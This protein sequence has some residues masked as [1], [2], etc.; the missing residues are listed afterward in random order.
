MNVQELFFERRLNLCRKLGLEGSS[1]ALITKPAHI[2]YF[3][4]LYIM[5]YERFIGLVLSLETWKGYL[6]IP[7]LEKGLPAPKDIE[8]IAYR[9][10]EDPFLKLLNIIKNTQVLWV[11]KNEISLLAFEK[12]MKLKYKLEDIFDLGNV[13]EE[14]KMIKDAVEIN[15]LGTAAHYADEIL[16]QVKKAIKVGAVEKQIKFE[17]LKNIA[18]K[19]GVQGEAFDIQVSS[20][21]HSSRPHGLT[22]DRQFEMGDAVIIDFGVSYA[23][24]KSDM[25]RTFF[26]GCPGRQMEE[27]YHVVLEAQKKA[28]AAV[29]PG[30]SI[31]E[32]DLAARETIEASGYGQYFIHRTGHGL[33]IDIHEAPSICD[34]NENTIKEGMVFSVEPGIYIP[35]VGGV[36][37]EDVVLVTPDGGKV[38]T[39]FP[40]ELADVILT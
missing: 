33:G 19:K 11:E 25:T 22:G 1:Y 3:T 5:P 7:E 37:I 18:E 20:G 14:M 4:G 15:A 39:Q 40:K 12:I 38:L 16:V 36:R 34:S 17:L 27:I 26:I 2:L 9:D 35:E 13:I 32:V 10:E 24:Y 28:I 31:R 30:R 21:P 23:Y 8:L 6:I 29:A